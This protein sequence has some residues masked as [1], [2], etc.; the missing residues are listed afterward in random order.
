MRQRI[1]ELEATNIQLQAD[2]THWEQQTNHW[3]LKAN[4]T[5]VERQLM[6]RRRSR[7]AD[8][9]TGEWQPAAQQSAVA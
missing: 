2:V 4:Y 1:A 3:Y 8:E 6:Y 5:D 9:L 7:G